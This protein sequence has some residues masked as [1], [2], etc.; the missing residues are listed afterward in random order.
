MLFGSAASQQNT[1]PLVNM[2]EV[3]QQLSAHAEA[4]SSLFALELQEYG[5]RQARRSALYAAA[6]VAA[7]VSY[8][9]LCA[10]AVLLLQSAWGW[11][12]ALAA[13]CGVHVVAAVALVTAALRCDVG[14]PAPLTCRELKTDWQCLKLILNTDRK[15]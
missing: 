14:E 7:F 4:L 13:V 3:G 15:S 2:Q 5:R 12:W 9:L 6:G 1:S 10:L 8:L 11:G